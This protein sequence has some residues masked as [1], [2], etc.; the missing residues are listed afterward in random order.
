MTSRETTTT[1]AGSMVD[2]RRF[3]GAC[4]CGVLTLVGVGCA[5]VAARPATVKDGLIELRLADHPALQKPGGSLIIQPDGSEDPLYVLALDN[6]EYSVLSPICT[7][8]GCTVDIAGALLVC[9]C[10]G[11]TYNRQGKVLEGPAPLPLA[12]YG[13]RLTTPGVLMIDVGAP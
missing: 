5:S 8:K 3:L 10:H 6:G 11:S 1:D 4:G 2:R 7:H 13:A 12:R 9:P